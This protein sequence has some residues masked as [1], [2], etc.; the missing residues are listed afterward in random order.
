MFDL[1]SS[2]RNSTTVTVNYTLRSNADVVISPLGGR[3]SSFAQPELYALTPQGQKF[4]V[5]RQSAAGVDNDP[6]QPALI[7]R[8][9]LGAGQTY[10]GRLVFNIPESVTSLRT[11][12][13]GYFMNFGTRTAADK[14]AQYV[15]FENVPI[16]TQAQL[17]QMRLQKEREKFL[18]ILTRAEGGDAAAQYQVALVFRDGGAGERPDADKAL[19][20]MEKSAAGGNLDA[21]A[22][23][24]RFYYEGTGG[25][26][27]YEKAAQYL[28]PAAEGG[29]LTAVYYLGLM[30]HY[31]HG[32]EQDTEQAMELFEIAAEA[33]QA[34][35]QFFYGRH[36]ASQGDRRGLTMLES[37]ASKGDLNAMATLGDMYYY[38]RFNTVRDFETAFRYYKKAVDAGGTGV[39]EMR[40]AF[41][42]LTGLGVNKDLDEA[43]RLYSQVLALANEIESAYINTKLGDISVERNNGQAAVD[44]YEKAIESNTES[45]SDAAHSLG[46]LYLEGDLVL[47][48]PV[49]ARQYLQLAAEKGNRDGQYDFA[50]LLKEEGRLTEAFGWYLKSAEQGKREAQYEVGLMYFY[51]KGT[52]RNN[53]EAANWI[54]KSYRNRY[55]PAEEAWNNLELWKYQ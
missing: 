8:I 9:N 24:G 47:K 33:G 12:Y 14:T 51:A 38:G 6:A 3:G 15:Q 35:A 11:L 23:M 18:Q 25:E 26:A 4:T 44:Y 45:S 20:W 28:V 53:R 31:G 1:V 16:Y 19:L 40:L 21:C 52:A 10:S 48:N 46:M 37:S 55:A 41:C 42:Y 7:Q 39:H 50:E 27:D 29:K 49:K 30:L 43:F 32:Y 22:E 13:I 34:G 2:S 5:T 36:L 54:E 17:E